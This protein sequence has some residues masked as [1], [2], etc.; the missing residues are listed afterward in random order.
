MPAKKRKS[1]AKNSKSLGDVWRAVSTA[2]VGDQALRRWRTLGLGAMGVVVFAVFC[3]TSAKVKEEVRQD[4]RLQ[5]SEWELSFGQLPAWV[6]PE[7]EAELEE[8]E[9]GGGFDVNV[10]DQGAMDRVREALEANAWVRTVKDLKLRYPGRGSPGVVE[11]ALWLRRPVA[12]VGVRGLYYLVDSEGRRVGGAYSEPPRQWFGVPVLVGGPDARLLPEVGEKW[13]Q[14]SVLE[15]VEVARILQD[16][17]I[18]AEYGAESIDAIDLSNLHGRLRPRES[19]IVLWR[20]RQQLAWGRSPLS[21]GARTVTTA[22]LLRNLRD[23][24]QH[25]ERYHEY[26]VINLHR[27]PRDVTGVRG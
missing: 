5:L 27:R 23:F 13:R 4:R 26:A 15:G 20:G 7:I 25:P 14:Q 12:I 19:E 9:L 8:T 16:E 2:L 10:L 22:D 17:G 18:F 11:A 24:L 3:V 6:T 21:A 1:R